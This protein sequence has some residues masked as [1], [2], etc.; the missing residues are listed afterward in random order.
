ME[1]IRG[2]RTGEVGRGR[3]RVV[4]ISKNSDIQRHDGDASPSCGLAMATVIRKPT[5]F[6]RDNQLRWER[7]NTRVGM[8]THAHILMG[9]PALER[10]R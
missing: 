9:A 1:V 3:C 2:N 6:A 7:Q 8:P 10:R 4:V 5:Q